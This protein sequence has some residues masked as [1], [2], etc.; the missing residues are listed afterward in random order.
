MTRRRST[1]AAMPAAGGELPGAQRAPLTVVAIGASAGGLDAF[2]RLLDT[3]PPDGGMAFILVQHLDP[4]HPSLMVELLASHTAMTVRQAADGMQLEADCIYVIPP[5]SYLALRAGSLVVSPPRPRRGARLPFDFLL[6][7]LASEA[8]ARAIAVVLSG[9][10]ADGSIGLKAVRQA[11]GFVIAQDPDDASHD[12][13]P[14]SAIATGSVD[15]VLPVARIAEALLERAGGLPRDRMAS[16]DPTPR[17]A[18]PWLARIIRLL[19]ER[20]AHNFTLYKSGTLQRRI[21]RRLASAGI[22]SGDHERYLDLLRDDAKELDLLAKDLL[23][24][25]TGFFRDP[26]VFDLLSERIIP[27]LIKAHATELPL[28]IWI[29]GCSTGEETYSLA[30]LF[31]EQLDASG[32]H[33]KLQVFASDVDPGVVAAA[34]EGVYPETIA[35]VVSPARLARFFTHE[36]DSYRVTPELRSAV[37]FT[38]QDLLADPPFSKL[39]LISC[40]NLLI[41]L[42]PEAQEK[43]LSLFHFALREGGILVLGSAETIGAD[44]RRFAAIAKPERI[45]RHVGRNRP[46][47]MAFLQADGSGPRAPDRTPQLQAPSHQSALAELCRRYVLDSYAP[48]AMLVNRRNECVYSL[49][50]TDRFLHVAPGHVTNDVVAMAR[51]GVRAKLRVALQRAAR[52][53]AKVTVSGSAASLPGRN[54]AFTLVVEP[55]RADGEELLL[56]C[57][58]DG[59]KPAPAPD[60]PAGTRDVSRIAELERELE[61]TRGELENA[62]RSLEISTEAQRA[63]DDEARSVNEEYQATNEELLTSK[64]ELQSLNEE[65]TALNSQLQESLERQRTTSNDLQNILYSTHVATLFLDRSLN[66]R[67]F[68]P[69]DPGVVQRS[70]RR[71]RETARPSQLARRRFP[72]ARRCARG[73]AE[74]CAARARDRGAERRVVPAPH[75]AVSRPGRRGRR[76]RDHLHRHHRATTDRRSAGGGQA[77]GATRERRQVAL[78]RRRQP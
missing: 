21:E 75:P 24:N 48:A 38:V 77:R 42:L 47:E 46:G 56:V 78:P 15:V 54:P 70:S 52:D 60:T 40:R 26:K 20:T 69:G 30:M 73:A 39:D 16:G 49:G 51:V 35:S 10:G 57:F 61:G 55:M 37:V 72:A 59:P 14:R 25:V 22:A 41:Y 64:E 29:A 13:M 17:A 9:T 67:F 50:P 43:V 36:G 58:V 23:I 1:L 71:Y 45:F 28:R 53:N 34:R 19:R 63:I 8:G 6:Q 74:A 12:G 18:P 66:I 65:L 68:T 7:S 31:R 32:R 33:I 3:L 44:D 5:G 11:G 27:E 2:Q 76:R 4:N 62:I